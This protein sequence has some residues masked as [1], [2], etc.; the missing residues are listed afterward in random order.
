MYHYPLYLDDDEISYSCTKE[1][2]LLGSVTTHQSEEE[3]IQL[4]SFMR[5]RNQ[6]WFL[7]CKWKVLYW[8]TSAFNPTIPLANRVGA[9]HRVQ[10]LSLSCLVSFDG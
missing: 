7:V 10:P 2:G 5:F 1:S 8:Q 4:V 9:D 3:G 6:A